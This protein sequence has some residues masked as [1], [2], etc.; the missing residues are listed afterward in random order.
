MFEI[1]EFIYESFSIIRN[2][3]AAGKL[4]ALVFIFVS[5]ALIRSTKSAEKS[6]ISYIS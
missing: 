2:L 5:T 4:T 1:Y 3:Y 6:A